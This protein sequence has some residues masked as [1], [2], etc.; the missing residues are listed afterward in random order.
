MAGAI[1]KDVGRGSTTSELIGITARLALKSLYRGDGSDTDGGTTYP[2]TTTA[3]V[4]LGW[5]AANNRYEQVIVHTLSSTV[6]PRKANIARAVWKVRVVDENSAATSW[7]FR[8]YGL[9]VPATSGVTVTTYDGTNTWNSG[10]YGPRLGYDTTASTVGS[11]TITSTDVGNYIDVDITSE[12]QYALDSQSGVLRLYVITFSDTNPAPGGIDYVR[13]NNPAATAAS[14]HSYL[15]IDYRF[16][17]A[18]YQ[19]GTS[20]GRPIDVAKHLNAD[21]PSTDDRL[22]LGT[23]DQGTAGDQKKF[24]VKNTRTGQRKRVVVVNGLSDYS[25]INNSGSVSGNKL[26]YLDTFDNLTGEGTS[27]GTL[28]IIPDSADTT[29]YKVYFTPTGG[30]ETLLA[31]NSTALTSVTFAADHTFDYSSKKHVKIPTAAWTS[32]TGFNS[33]DVFRTTLKASSIPSTYNTAT[34]SLTHIANDNSDAMDTTKKKRCDKARADQF[35]DVPIDRTISTVTRTHLRMRDTNKFGSATTTPYIDVLRSDGTTVDR[36][37]VETIYSRTDAT[38]PN[39]IRL[40]SQIT[41]GNYSTSSIVCSGVLAG[42]L[43]SSNE[44]RLSV[45]HA[46]GVTT[47]TLTA[48]LS[49]APA[50]GDKATLLDLSNGN[51]EVVTISSQTGNNLTLQAATTKTYAANAL[52]IYSETISSE[53]FWMQATTEDT[54]AEGNYLAFMRAMEFRI[55]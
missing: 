37:A 26:R 41:I 14:T 7:P 54:T 6:V 34:L 46:A 24:Y 50:N 11:Y 53:P 8:V 17:T 47:L 33:S 16:S 38:Y 29:K 5:S 35:W 44:S 45:S 21:S 40:A 15:Q 25:P 13:I 31:E 48:A 32:T 3:Q 52:V 30:A 18:F 22:Y 19:A 9:R 28:R 55:V 27:E 49:P 12:V 1:S 36:Y 2:G 51:N 10:S 42:T 4:E 23:P 43:D 39:E 20:S